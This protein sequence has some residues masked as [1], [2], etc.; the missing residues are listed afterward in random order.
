VLQRALSENYPWIVDRLNQGHCDD[1]DHSD[2]TT[3]DVVTRM[4]S[5][6][7]GIG[8]SRRVYRLTCNT[9]TT[10]GADRPIYDVSYK[11]F[12]I[13]HRLKLRC[14]ARGAKLRRLSGALV[15]KCP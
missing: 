6:V 1:D 12:G 8:Q 9:F 13:V 5:R 7:S 11:Q 15:R 2:S 4:L 14:R 10:E 3:H